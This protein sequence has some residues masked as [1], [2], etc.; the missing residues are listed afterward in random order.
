MCLVQFLLLNSFR[1]LG[2]SLRPSVHLELILL[3]TVRRGNGLVLSSYG[4][5]GFLTMLVEDAYL[6]SKVYC[7]HLC[8][9][10]GS[11]LFEYSTVVLIDMFVL[12]LL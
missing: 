5:P 11:F 12:P 6:S 10:L 7:W 4:Y 8:Q 1:A 3:C 2:S 9:K